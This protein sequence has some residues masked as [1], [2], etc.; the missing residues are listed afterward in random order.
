MGIIIG[1][2]EV[3]PLPNVQRLDF[4]CVR[5]MDRHDIIFWTRDSYQLLR[6]SMR[7]ST[8]ATASYTQQRRL[9]QDTE[10]LEAT[11]NLQQVR[12]AQMGTF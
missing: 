4:A 3:S 12:A 9:R 8:T 11:G 6:E 7:M 1:A 2:S 10:T 5:V